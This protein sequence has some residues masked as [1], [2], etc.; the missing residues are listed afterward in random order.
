MNN[1]QK[2]R[3][4]DN[5]QY[6]LKNIRN[7]L[8]VDSTVVYEGLCS[9]LSYEK[10]ENGKNELNLFKFFFFLERMGVSNERFEVMIPNHIYE[11][12]NWYENC[13]V[14]TEKRDWEGLRDERSKFDK[15]ELEDDKI[16]I[17]YRDYVDYIIARY[18]YMDNDKAKTFIHKALSRTVKDIKDI[19]KEKKRLSIF[20][21][22][23]F[24]NLYDLEYEMEP[25]KNTEITDMMIGIYNYYKENTNEELIVYRVLPKL[26]LTILLNDRSRLSV[27]KRIKIEKEIL[28]IAV[29]YFCWK[30]VPEVLKLL[31]IDVKSLNEEIVYTKQREALVNIL[32]RYGFSAEYRVEIYRGRFPAFT[33][34]SNNIKAHRKKMGLTMEEISEEICAVETYSRYERG[35]MYPKRKRLELLAE[36]LGLEWF[37]I[38]VD[39]EVDDYNSLLLASECR[40][41]VAVKEIDTFWEKIE[42]LKIGLDM[43]ITRN[44]FAVEFFEIMSKNYS[45]ITIKEL[46]ELISL[47]N[48]NYSEERFYSRMEIEV[49][50]YIGKLEGERN[51]ELGIRILKNLI[52]NVDAGQMRDKHY[53]GIPRRNLMF[54]YADNKQ[55]DKSYD[56][57]LKLISEILAADD[58]FLIWSILDYIST[59]EEENGNMELAAEICRDMFYTSELYKKYDTS[60]GVKKYYEKYFDEKI[61]WY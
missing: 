37:L 38:R 18:A 36:G 31:L 5:P 21:W 42:E 20:E 51:A 50:S 48:K 26:G 9:K 23:I 40:Y 46:K 44:K 57:G 16:Q 34:F 1:K 52:N 56:I 29:K 45:E 54:L 19:I 28:D 2:C 58:I 39:M 10:Y 47:M 13:M 15:I 11:F 33:L 25:N 4:T 35:V 3:F 53:S 55:Y 30:I 8:G 61:I 41:L 22:N 14:L 32:N 24:I 6:I 27:A 49:L 43:G 7:T 59:I 12:Y 60:K 17:S